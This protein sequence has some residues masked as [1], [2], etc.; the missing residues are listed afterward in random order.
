MHMY[1][2]ILKGKTRTMFKGEIHVQHADLPLTLPLLQDR[3]W[4]ALLFLRW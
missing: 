3:I 2:S 1:H 4:V